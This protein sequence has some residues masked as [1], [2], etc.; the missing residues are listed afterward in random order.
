[1]SHDRTKGTARYC[2]WA[3][4]AALAC[5]L[6][7]FA[8]A[9]QPPEGDYGRIP[10]W[11]FT[12]GIS[13]AGVYDSNVGLAD[14]PALIGRTESDRLFMIQPSGRFDYLS[15][16]TIFSSGYS[17]YLRRYMDVN[18]LNGFDQ[19]FD[20]SLRRLA[21]K[22]LTFAV[23][24]SFMNVPTT[25]EVELNGVPFVRVGTRTNSLEASMVARLTK[26]T[27][28]NIGYENTW[29]SF[30]RSE[31]PENNF[32]AGGTV[33]GVHADVSHVM[34]PRISL[35]AEYG[36][37]V[38]NLN[39]GLQDLTFQDVGATAK[40]IFGPHTVLSVAGGFSHLT[41]HSDG[42]SRTGPYVR[43]GVTHA[44][45]RATLGASFQRSFVPSFGFGGTNQSQEL[46]GFVRMPIS[47]SRLYVQGSAAW[48]RTDPLLEAELQA[49]TIW[50]RSTLGYSVS[51]WFRVE[52][53]H[54]FTRQDSI[55]TGG[56][57]NRQRAGFQVVI[58]QPMRIR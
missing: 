30:D 4:T 38:A 51:R 17:G 42:T 53:F 43:M 28:L 9:Q 5:G 10:G 49:D 36:L 7:S 8:A 29:V 26:F 50:I 20:M 44:I 55:V 40:Y 19:R 39:E 57:I 21:T 16:R 54:T 3:A 13:V 46:R 48:R 47:R 6:P 14:A 25:D 22:R 56:E 41:D 34:N 31:Q 1:M 32:L 15:P 37:R 52:G 27:D 35:G 45:E 33:S 18:Q 24:D 58:S 11:T 12:P 23:T 2:R